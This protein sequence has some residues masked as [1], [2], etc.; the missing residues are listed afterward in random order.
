MHE[1]SVLITDVDNTLL[2]WVTIWHASFSAMFAKLVE[3]SGLPAE[4]LI[5]EI[6]SVHQRH[7]TSEYAFLINEVPLLKRAAGDVDV[8][9]FYKD[10]IDAF[11]DARRQTLALYPGVME[12]LS[13]VKSKGA[14]II[15]YT[16]SKA[17]YTEYR[18]RKLGLDKVIDYLYS[19][20]DH[21]LPAGISKDDLRRYPDSHYQMEK[22]QHRHTPEGELK[23]NPA[24]L[25]DI[26]RDVGADRDQAVY[27]GDSLI[28]D[29]VMAKD[30][31][32]LDAHAAY[33]AA[34]HTDAYSLL[35]SVTHWTT[36]DVKREARINKHPP[37]TP[38]I[39]LASRMDELTQSVRFKSFESEMV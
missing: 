12:F 27:V 23:P 28:K 13:G 5:P 35:K 38:S 29:I 10:A 26:L 7:G 14:L 15:A 16:E 33:G 20:P 30:V 2:D 22:T 11:R 24:I 17:F 4:Q 36:E 9:E 6:R 31:G 18:F 3:R 8:R 1:R 34:Q 39:T 19:P 32:I 21:E 25:A 37:V